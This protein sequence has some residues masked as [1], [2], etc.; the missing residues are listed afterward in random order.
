M[1]TLFQVSTFSQTW[2]S[3]NVIAFQAWNPTGLKWKKGRKKSLI[4]FSIYQEENRNLSLEI[5]LTFWQGIK[6]G[7]RMHDWSPFQEIK[8]LHVF[9]WP[10]ISEIVSVTRIFVVLWWQKRSFPLCSKNLGSCVSSEF[11]DL[12]SFCFTPTATEVLQCFQPLC[13][14]PSRGEASL[15]EN[16]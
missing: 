9:K 12:L 1:S 16:V 14:D 10:R 15:L 8:G 7:L 6:W 3:I 2:Q 5:I 11:L 4:L 13:L